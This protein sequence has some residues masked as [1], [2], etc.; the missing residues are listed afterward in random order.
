[1]FLRSYLFMR[2]TEREAEMQAAGRFPAEQGARGGTPSQHPGV[3]TPWPKAD[4][5]PLSHPGALGVVSLL[6]LFHLHSP[7]SSN[8]CTEGVCSVRCCV[9]Q[10][11]CSQRCARRQDAGTE[12]AQEPCSPGPPSSPLRAKNLRVHMG[13]LCTGSKGRM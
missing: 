13:H 11:S 8:L 12:E 1:M 2:D 10:G 3:T 4:T 9:S 5:Q 6:L 7:S